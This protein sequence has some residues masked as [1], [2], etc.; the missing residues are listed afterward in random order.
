MK[1]PRRFN[2]D[3]C[4]LLMFKLSLGIAVAKLSGKHLG[5]LI[6]GYP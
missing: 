5:R 4:A 2:A 6:K 3:F 1:K